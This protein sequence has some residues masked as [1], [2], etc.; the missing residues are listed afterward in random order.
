MDSASFNMTTRPAGMAEG[1]AGTATE[2]SDIVGQKILVAGTKVPKWRA[3]EVNWLP[4]PNCPTCVM[5][6]T[7]EFKLFHQLNDHKVISS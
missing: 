4:W 1:P 5:M 3:Q 7:L 2:Q 6:P